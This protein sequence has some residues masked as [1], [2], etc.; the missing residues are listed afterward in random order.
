MLVSNFTQLLL[1]NHFFNRLF[2]FFVCLFV[3]LN[4]FVSDLCMLSDSCIGNQCK[5]VA[6][7]RLKVTELEQ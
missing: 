5:V 7:R 6:N 2:V 3:F 1:F 4:F